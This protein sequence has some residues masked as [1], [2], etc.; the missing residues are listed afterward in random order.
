MLLLPDVCPQRVSSNVDVVTV[1]HLQ[2][3]DAGR[4]TIRR[5]KTMSKSRDKRQNKR[6]LQSC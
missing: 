3:G 5:T 6:L 4:V 2:K 1:Q